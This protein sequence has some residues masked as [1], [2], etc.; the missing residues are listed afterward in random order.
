MS[1]Q[2]N[3]TGVTDM[4]FV[5]MN[6]GIQSQILTHLKTLTNPPEID[7]IDLFFN[8]L[9]KAA[10]FFNAEKDLADKTKPSEVRNNLNAAVVAAQKLNDCLVQLDANSLALI[11]EVRN[12]SAYELQRICQEKILGVLCQADLKADEYPSKGR[13]NENHRLFLALDVAKAI[14]SHLHVTPTTTKDGLYDAILSIVL[15]WLT[16]REVNSSNDLARK[17]LNTLKSNN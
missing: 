16:N 1:R 4:A 10:G 9:E 3:A 13:L 11:T 17:A 15:G 7:D 2:W 8:A 12:G 5:E 6:A 14:Q